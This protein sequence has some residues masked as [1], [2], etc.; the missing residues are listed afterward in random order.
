MGECV[1]LDVTAAPFPHAVVDDLWDADL[2]GAV[3]DSFPDPGD[4]VWHRFDNAKERKLGSSGDPNDW[5]EPVRRFLDLLTGPDWVGTLSDAF[6]IPDLVGD[7]YGGGMHMIPPG[8]LLDVHVDFN[9]HPNGSYRRL[10]CLVYLNDDWQPGMG[11]ELELRGEPTLTIAPTFNR[12]VVFATSDHSWHGHPMPT[13]GYW[14]RSI[15]VYYFAPVPSA[16]YAA[17]HDTVFA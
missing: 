4:R 17:P 13:S 15:A 11:G 3:R 5:P 1:N 6:G 12:T 16:D 7:T 9:R 14:R 10:N 2:L 8:G